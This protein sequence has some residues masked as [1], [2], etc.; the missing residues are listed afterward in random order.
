MTCVTDKT[1]MKFN[2]NGKKSIDFSI[3]FNEQNE[4]NNGTWW[5]YRYQILLIPLFFLTWEN[6]C[7]SLCFITLIYT[8]CNQSLLFTK[9]ITKH[10]LY[11]NKRDAYFC[12]VC[13]LFL[14]YIIISLVSARKTL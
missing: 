10:Y 12:R 13:S 11:G 4:H 5:Y 3:L 6:I 9:K 2:E 1:P 7:W 14:P 8:S